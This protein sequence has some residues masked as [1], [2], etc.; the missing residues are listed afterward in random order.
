MCFFTCVV[1][2]KHLKKKERGGRDGMYDGDFVKKYRVFLLNKGMSQ[3]SSIH[4][5]VLHALPHSL[6]CA[7]P[8]CIQR[9][10]AQNETEG[11]V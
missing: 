6:A 4:T 10:E 7:V 11:R 5:S 1:L 9:I 2:I 3:Q 8:R